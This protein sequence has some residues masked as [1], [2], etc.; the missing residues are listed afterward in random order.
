LTTHFFGTYTV[1]KHVQS[2]TVKLHFLNEYSCIY[3]TKWKGY[4]STI[5]IMSNLALFT[6]EQQVHIASPPI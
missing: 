2:S 6:S 4:I 5:G 1:T 3:L